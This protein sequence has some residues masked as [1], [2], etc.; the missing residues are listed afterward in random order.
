LIFDFQVLSFDFQ[1][2]IFCFDFQGF[3]RTSPKGTFGTECVNFWFPGFDFQGFSWTIPKGP[4]GTECGN[5]GFPG[6]DFLFWFSVFY[7]KFYVS[8]SRFWFSVLIFPLDKSQRALWHRVRWFSGFDFS[9][10]QVPTLGP[11][12]QSAVIFRFWFL[13]SSFDVDF[14]F[15]FIFWFSGF[16]LDESQR[17]LWQRVP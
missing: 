3:P 17:A 16:P 12:A 2:L 7:F 1:V 8:I 15:N 14:G 5:F 6:F 4:F 11:L 10:G 13:I 9:L